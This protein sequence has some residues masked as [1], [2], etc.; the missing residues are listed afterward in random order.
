M[1]VD[2]ALLLN[3]GN[4]DATTGTQFGGEM[5]IAFCRTRLSGRNV[6]PVAER[7][8]GE[9]TGHRSA[10]PDLVVAIVVAAE[11]CALRAGMW[12]ARTDDLIATGTGLLPWRDPHV[13]TRI[14][15]DVATRIGW[16]RRS[17]SI[18]RS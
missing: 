12:L 8:C 18:R 6:C 4:I 5:V 16:W 15:Y 7:C 14:R 11:M 3:R 9:R 10:L 2:V 1:S 13:K 17:W